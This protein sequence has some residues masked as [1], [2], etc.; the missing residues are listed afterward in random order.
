MRD[1]LRLSTTI[2]HSTS[3]ITEE[4]EQQLLSHSIVA[5]SYA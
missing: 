2:G 3:V 5:V 4:G 1:L